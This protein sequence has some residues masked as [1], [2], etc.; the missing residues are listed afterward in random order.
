MILTT[1][2]KIRLA[3]VTPLSS[4][5]LPHS[6]NLPIAPNTAVQNR[7]GNSI[8]INIT[9]STINLP[10]ALA[11]SSI[12]PPHSMNLVAVSVKN[13]AI[14]LGISLIHWKT[15]STAFLKPSQF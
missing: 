13:S 8:M 3:L 11:I 6:A 7:N 4:I 5:L 9:P 2:D 14:L 15:A 1:L 12:L 10:T